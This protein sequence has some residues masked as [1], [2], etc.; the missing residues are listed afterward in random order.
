MTSVYARITRGASRVRWLRWDSD[1]RWTSFFAKAW[2]LIH[3]GADPKGGVADACGPYIA[4]N[5]DSGYEV[6]SLM[7]H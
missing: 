4:S 6:Q 1:A 2:R 3:A 7:Q 5:F